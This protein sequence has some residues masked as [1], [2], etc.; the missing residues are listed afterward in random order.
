MSSIQDNL[1]QETIT[2]KKEYKISIVKSRF[3]GDIT[4][5]LLESCTEELI[6][7]GVS[8]KNIQIIEMP[9]AFEIPYACQKIAMTK[10]NDAIIA[11]GAII[12][13]DTPHFDYVAEGVTSGTMEV[14]LKHNIPVIFGVLTTDNKEQAIARI[15][16][17]NHGD[18]GIEIA[19]ATVIT[20]NNTEGL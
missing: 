4:N 20:L 17:G 16:G 12:R 19:Q 13:G 14:S 2:A 1:S 10:E 6:K 11:I 9:G 18:K 5:A 15:K 7:S 3:N 8:K